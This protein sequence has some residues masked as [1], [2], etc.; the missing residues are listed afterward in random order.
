MKKSKIIIFNI[1]LT[2]II[3]EISLYTRLGAF[4]KVDHN[5][6]DG[7]DVANIPTQD[8]LKKYDKVERMNFEFNTKF[9][10]NNEGFRD[11]YFDTNKN[12]I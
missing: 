10:T 9:T 3:I 2:F 7:F 5:C 4:L 1:L 6:L 11:N 8:K 12:K